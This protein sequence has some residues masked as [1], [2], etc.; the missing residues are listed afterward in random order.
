MAVKINNT[1]KVKIPAEKVWD[2]LK[3]FGGLEKYAPTIAT[4]PITNNIN[5]GLGAI[6]KC[7]FFN[8]SSMSEEII[9]YQEGRGYKIKIIEHQ[10]PFVR[11]NSEEIY[12]VKIDN[13]TSEIN[14]SVN[15]EM[16]GGPL[17]WMMGSFML[18]PMM[19]TVTKKIITGLAYHVKTGKLVSDKLPSKDD[20]QFIL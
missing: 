15:F 18:K 7:V 20:L 4:S 11:S 14:M 6:R 13:N 12:V 5:T 9:D 17:G 16:S 1:I 8:D 3:D 2:V 19:N 10:M